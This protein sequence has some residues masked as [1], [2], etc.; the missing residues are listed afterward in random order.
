MAT[1]PLS[2]AIALRIAL[3]SKAIPEGSAAQLLRVLDELIGLP[4]TETKLAQL[5]VKQLK[6][7]A[8]GELAEVDSDILKQVVALLKGEGGE[9]VPELPTIEPYQ[10]GELG[11]SI[12]VAFA[13]DSGRLIDGHF[14]SCRYYL[15]YQ[16]AVEATKLVDIREV[17][18]DAEAEDKNGYRAGLINDCQLLFVASIGGPAAAKVVRAGI[19][20][21]K[22]AQGGAIDDHLKE[23]QQAIA[24][25][26]PPWLAK[27]MGQSPEQRVRFE[28]EG[29]E[30]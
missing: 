10:L 21:L 8:E 22:K 18:R 28:R 11:D 19:H 20:P 26:P 1:P 23:L 5:S 15:I 3:A 24:T 16:V 17:D 6:S 4:P 12:R 2:D 14:G 27:A 25:T 13:S 29:V 7:A 9:S 30:A